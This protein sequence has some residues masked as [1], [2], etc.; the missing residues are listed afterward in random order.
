MVVW[1]ARTYNIPFFSYICLFF[2]SLLYPSCHLSAFKQTR[3]QYSYSLI[4][5]VIC[6]DYIII[7][8]WVITIVAVVSLEYLIFTVLLD[9]SP[10]YGFPLSVPL[11]FFPFYFVFFLYVKKRGRGPFCYGFGHASLCHPNNQ[12]KVLKMT[13][14]SRHFELDLLNSH[15]ETPFGFPVHFLSNLRDVHYSRRKLGWV[16]V[17]K[18]FWDCSSGQGK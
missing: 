4:C 1:L 3:K 14:I 6:N 10:H 2:I 12:E 18:D 8:F 11:C 13:G 15:S 16:N 17:R 7:L 5:F 9:A